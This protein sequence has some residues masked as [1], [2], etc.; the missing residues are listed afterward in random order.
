MERPFASWNTI[1]V[2]RIA[3][4]RGSAGQRLAARHILPNRETVM[5]H[6]P[7]PPSRFREN[8]VILTLVLV[9]G[10]VIIFFL[11][12]ISFGIFTYAIAVGGAVVLLGFV[13]Y[14][15]WGRAMSEEVAAERDAM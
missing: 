10:G 9:L 6:E 7:A 11:D 1:N 14:V 5:D 4:D 8:A 12:L 2:C 3:A 13:H 15:V